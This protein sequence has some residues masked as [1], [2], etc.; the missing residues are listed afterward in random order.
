MSDD[1]LCLMAYCRGQCTKSDGMHCRSEQPGEIA[2][3]FHGTGLAP[4]AN[5]LSESIEV[6]DVGGDP[7]AKKRQPM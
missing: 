1:P 6:I 4:D 3:R 5:L 2:R 7:M